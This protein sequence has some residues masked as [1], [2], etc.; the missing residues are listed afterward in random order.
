MSTQ[1]ISLPTLTTVTNHLRAAAAHP[2]HKI[3]AK[4]MEQIFGDDSGEGTRAA[5]SLHSMLSAIVAGRSV[6]L[7]LVKY[8]RRL[9]LGKHYY[10]CWF[11]TLDGRI[12]ILWPACSEMAKVFGMVE[13]NRDTDMRKWL[14]SSGAIGMSRSFHA[15]QGLSRIVTEL[16]GHNGNFF[17]GNQIL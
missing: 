1:Q 15:M 12:D 4:R 2:Y 16:T 11:V 8:P 7:N 6:F 9:D 17:D 14:F 5:K 13:N 10:E 3:P